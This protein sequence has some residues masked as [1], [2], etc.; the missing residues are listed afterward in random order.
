MRTYGGEVYRL[1]V[2]TAVLTL[3]GL[4]CGVEAAA[5]E[6]G[7]PKPALFVVRV[8]GKNGFINAKG[9]L[10]IPPTFRKAYPFSDGLAAVS[11]GGKWGFIDTQGRTVIEPRF[12]MAGF[13]SDGLARV[14]S[15][16]FTD[17]WGYIDKT[18]KLIIRPQFD[19]AGR[20][21]NG[22]ARVGY[23][24]TRSQLLSRIADVG[25]QCD[26]RFIN[27]SGEFV[28][29]PPA[30]HYATGAPGELIRFEKEGRVGY[31]NAAGKVVIEPQFEAGADFS[32]G[33]ARVRG[34]GPFGYIDKSGRFVIPPRFENANDFSEGLAGVPLGEEGW[35]FIDGTGKVVIEPRFGWIY[36][37]FRHGLAEV[38]FD[39]KT[40]YIDK[41]G[42][43]V[44]K[45]SD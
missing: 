3:T 16:Q 31:L 20:F 5:D 19:C 24:T 25:I 17:P 1:S 35:G 6:N 34:K 15:R 27:T 22:I 44:W 45:P 28:P 43:W 23:Q 29:K 18:G 41:Q 26:D 39:G 13:F 37:G 2:C 12:V 21:R 38:A 4:A 30:T 8:D 32:D 7:E 42:Q 10:V 14:R 33:L 40:G 36:G 9:E 11:V